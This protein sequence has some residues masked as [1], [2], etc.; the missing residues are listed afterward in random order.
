[1]VLMHL[2]FR[3]LFRKRG[4]IAVLIAA[5]AILIG[6]ALPASANVGTDGFT[7][8]GAYENSFAHHCQV[9]GVAHKGYEGVVCVD[10]VTGTNSNNYWAKGQIE[11]YCQTTAGVPAT[12]ERVSG[13]GTFSDGAGNIWYGNGGCGTGSPTAC[14]TARVIIPIFTIGYN[15]AN[16][17]N[18]CW[19]NPGSGW[20]IWTVA[21]G[22]TGVTLPVSGDEVLL[23]NNFETGHYYACPYVDDGNP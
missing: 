21:W 20:D 17:G 1:M 6:S 9:M 22:A 13:S 10:I 4:I 15:Y 14:T 19:D 8:L 11:V 18:E 7:V 16:A 3:K 5:T 12:C 23:T 2:Q